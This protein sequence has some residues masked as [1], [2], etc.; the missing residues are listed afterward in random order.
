MPDTVINV[1]PT[2]N[3]VAVTVLEGRKKSE[4]N[5]QA[6]KPEILLPHKC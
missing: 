2:C 5:S 3:L 1:L 6:P 4:L